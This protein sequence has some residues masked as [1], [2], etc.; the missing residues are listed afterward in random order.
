MTPRK[1]FFEGKISLNAD[2][3]IDDHITGVCVDQIGNI[4]EITN[5]R[6]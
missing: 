5:K 2:N 4:T 6:N 1:F 3:T